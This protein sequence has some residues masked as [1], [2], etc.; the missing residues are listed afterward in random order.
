M[1]VAV[2]AA[3]AAGACFA[4]AGVLQQSVAS[5]APAE[6]SLRVRL[7]ADLVRRPRWRAGIAAA[8]A[9]Y[10]FQAY[11]LSVAPLALVQPI[12]VTELIF[13]IPAS[14]RLRGVRLSGREWTGVAAVAG[15]L[16]A[17]L[18]G[19][20]PQ[21][22]ETDPA[23]GRW[24][25]ALAA[26]LGLAGAAVT[27]GRRVSGSVRV[28]A[29]AASAAVVLGTQ[30]GLL[31]ETVRRFADDGVLA[32]LASWP[33][34]VM[35]VA[36]LLGLLLVQSA[37]Q[38]GPLAVSLPV[39]DTVEPLTAAVVGV[40]VLGESIAVSAPHLSALAAGAA[41]LAAGIVT[42]DTSPAVQALHRAQRDEQ[43]HA[44]EELHP[45]AAAATCRAARRCQATLA[46]EQLN[47]AEPVP[48]RRPAA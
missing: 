7:L 35:T 39:V 48:G 24:A 37:F 3:L 20:S 21:G 9:S 43:R 23:S 13:A 2:V 5:A 14:A 46:E 38:A 31:D 29:Y 32:T 19:A 44:V 22:S 25:L 16:A 11:A 18:W 34:Y 4:L 47:A 28:S 36:S 26:A 41:L 12:I 6:R 27:L 17:A 15:G 30:S 8:F 40:A 10:G 33:P 42:L 45:V 1:T